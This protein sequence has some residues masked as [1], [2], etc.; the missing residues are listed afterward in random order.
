MKISELILALQ[1]ELDL[2][3]DVDVRESCEEGYRLISET[4]FVDRLEKTERVGVKAKDFV[5]F[6]TE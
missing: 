4:W 5:S 1:K 3:G 2:H 6:G